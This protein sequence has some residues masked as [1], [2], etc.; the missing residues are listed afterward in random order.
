V[1]SP[2]ITF[3]VPYD[4]DVSALGQVAKRGFFAIDDQELLDGAVGLV[5]DLIFFAAAVYLIDTII[6]NNAEFVAIGI[7]RN[8]VG[9]VG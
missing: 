6:G 9:G 5:D 3:F 7:K 4:V 8:A 1:F 2:Y